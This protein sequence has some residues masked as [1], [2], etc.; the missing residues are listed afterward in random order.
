VGSVVLKNIF[1]YVVI[2]QSLFSFAAVRTPNL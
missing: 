1:L 2:S